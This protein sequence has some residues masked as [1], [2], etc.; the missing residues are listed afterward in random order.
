[1]INQQTIT[2]CYNA[3]QWR[4]LKQWYREVR[5]VTHEHQSN[6]NESANPWPI[7][8]TS[9]EESLHHKWTLIAYGV[10]V[11][12]PIVLHQLQL[13]VLYS[14][15]EKEEWCILRFRR[16]DISLR[17]LFSDELFQCGVFLLWHEVYFAINSIRGVLLKFNHMV[18][19]AQWQEVVRFLL[20]KD[21][22]N[23]FYCDGNSTTLV[24]WLACIARSVKMECMQDCFSS[25]W[26]IRAW[27]GQWLSVK[28]ESQVVVSWK[29][30]NLT[31][32]HLIVSW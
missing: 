26:T 13:S 30:E 4:L 5:H 12:P 3:W 8:L 29:S 1:M 23:F 11:D 21:L 31:S 10:T 18:S 14:G 27:C 9:Q 32:S 7:G 17:Q 6:P 25:C 22:G 28:K 16:V 20:T 19:K 2:Y 24:C 15:D